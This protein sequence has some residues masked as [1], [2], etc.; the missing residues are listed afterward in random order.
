MDDNFQE[1]TQAL[2]TLSSDA[3]TLAAILETKDEYGEA[4]SESMAIVESW[5]EAN[6]VAQAMA[7]LSDTL[8]AASA[9]IVDDSEDS[10]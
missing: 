3:S 1:T 9:L 10:T 2:R 5:P 6:S 4:F 8:G 7:I